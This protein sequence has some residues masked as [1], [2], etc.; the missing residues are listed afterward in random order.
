MIPKKSAK[1]FSGQ[2]HAKKIAKAG[3]YYSRVYRLE[4]VFSSICPKNIGILRNLLASLS[5]LSKNSADAW[6]A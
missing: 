4:W 6:C 3:S 2:D 1:R 5:R